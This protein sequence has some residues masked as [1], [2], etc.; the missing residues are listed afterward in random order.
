LGQAVNCVLQGAC[1][2]GLE[3]T[4]VDLTTS[5]PC[6]VRQGAITPQEIQSVK[7]IPVTITPLRASKLKLDLQEVAVEKLDAVV[8]DLLERD[9]RVIVLARRATIR[10]NPKLQ[11][12]VMPCDVRGYC[13]LL[14]KTLHSLN[15]SE[16]SILIEALP[17]EDEWAGVIAHL[18]RFSL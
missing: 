8:S 9:Q 5:V 7:E 4:V 1:A 10:R 12:I 3:S 6:I 11:W 17:F 2:I 13:S 18:K 16:A 15:L 14:Y